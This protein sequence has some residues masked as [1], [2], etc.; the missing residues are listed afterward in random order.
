MPAPESD[1]YKRIFSENKDD[2]PSDNKDKKTIVEPLLGQA[3]DYYI[4]KQ[5]EEK[6]Q[7]K[8]PKFSN[9][10]VKEEVEDKGTFEDR[11]KEA[12]KITD[13]NEKVKVMQQIAKDKYEWKKKHGKL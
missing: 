9:P 10:F 8:K 6:Q 1:Y 4:S 5:K 3:K 12:L 11:V 2:Q 13:I 7:D